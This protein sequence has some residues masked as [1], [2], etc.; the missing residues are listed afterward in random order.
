VESS[1][2]KV[3]SNTAWFVDRRIGDRAVE[4]VQIE[5]EPSLSRTIGA[6]WRA[7]TADVVVINEAQRLL[8]FLCLVRRVAFRRRQI[9]VA[10]DQILKPPGTGLSALR[11]LIVRSL[12]REVRHFVFLYRDTDE[13]ARLY[14][15]PRDRISYIPFK[16]NSLDSVRAQTLRDDHY[17]LAC[18]RS[19]RDYATFC[20]A[21]A[22]LPIQGVI[23]APIGD[24]AREH[25]TVDE[26]ASVPSNVRVIRDDGSWESWLQWLSAATFVAIPILPP[27]LAASGIGTYLVA[28]ALGKCVVITDS[29]GTR[30]ILTPNEALVVPPRDP[31][32]MR[33]AMQRLLDDPALRDR[34]AK[35]G[36]EYA[37]S[38]GDE[39][40]LANDAFALVTKLVAARS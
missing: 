28:M 4:N 5:A 11:M 12:L 34:I 35:G 21:I 15:L 18:G 13:V 39:S 33:D 9:I 32:A 26:L 19:R 38:L 25:G 27:T 1:S 16:V 24:E 23:L 14:D 7:V 6:A 8:L 10:V 20:S 36:Q 2:V 30:G 3:F 37:L 22:G 40:R 31:A 29:P 17:V